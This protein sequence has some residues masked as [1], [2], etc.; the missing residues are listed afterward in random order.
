MYK[1]EKTFF[2][3]C[4]IGKRGMQVTWIG[5]VSNVGLTVSKG[6]AG[7]FVSNGGKIDW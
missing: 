4:L 1:N 6:A 5:C 3:F 2:F 7:W